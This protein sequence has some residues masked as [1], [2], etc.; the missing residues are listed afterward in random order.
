MAT[1]FTGR[2]EVS[3]FTI[4]LDGARASMTCKIY[5][6]WEDTDN[7]TTARCGDSGVIEVKKIVGI[8]KRDEQTLKSSIE[9]SIGVTGLAEL[10]SKIEDSVKRDFNFH[11]EISTSKTSNFLSPQ[12]GRKTIFVY[13]LIREYEFLYHQKKWG[14]MKTWERKIRERTNTHDYMPDIDEFDEVCKCKNPPRPENFD[15]VMVIDMGN[16]SIRAPYRNTQKEIE[17]MLETSVLKIPTEGFFKF[18]LIIPTKILPGMVVFLGDINED[19]VEAEYYE[20]QPTLETDTV[21]AI[22]AEPKK[23]VIEDQIILIEQDYKGKT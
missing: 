9:G 17:V 10:K 23:M 15:G 20:Y 19:N 7:T 22:V 21:Y 3:S 12:C 13:Q 11:T 6:H 14:R 8:S 5:E 2:K 4:L 1:Y 18:P 16:I